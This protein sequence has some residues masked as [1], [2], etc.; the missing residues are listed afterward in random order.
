MKHLSVH[1]PLVGKVQNVKDKSIIASILRVTTEV[2][3]VHYYLII[4][5]N[6]L[7]IVIMVN[8]VKQLLRGYLFIRLFQN[9]LLILQ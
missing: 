5:V 6:V 4:H 3:V 7:V 9:H 1:V 8:I 2:F